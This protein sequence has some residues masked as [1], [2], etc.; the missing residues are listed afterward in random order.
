MATI[1]GIDLGTTNSEVAVYDN[2]KIEIITDDDNGIVPSVV[3]LDENGTVIVGRQAMNQAL[4][5]PERTVLSIKRRMGSDAVIELGENTFSPQEI[6]AFVLKS[7]KQRAEK[8]LGRPVTRAV[9]TV[10]AYFTDVQRQATRE[11]GQIAGLDVVR[12]INE[13]TAAALTYERG[14]TQ[15]RQLLVYDLGG[16]TFDVS[17]V[18]IENGVVEVLASTGDN[19]LGGDDFDK[20]IV[21]ELVTHLKNKYGIDVS[22][23]RFVMAR[24]L[25]VAESA[26]CV[27]STEPYTRIEEDH[28]TQKNGQVIHLSMELSRSHFESL[29]EADLSRTMQAVTRALKDADMLPGAID[30]II[31]VGGST[32][33]PRIAQ[34][35]EEKFGTPPHGEIDPDLCVAMGAGIQSAREMGLDHA[36]VL[37]DITPYTF[38]TSAIGEINGEPSMSQFVPLIRRNTKLPA[39]RSEVFYTLY[40]NQEA[41]DV[42]VYQAKSPTPPTTSFWANICST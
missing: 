24:L 40:D 20:K 13:P 9:I 39:S 34:L 7:L 16:G 12:I 42:T 10:P 21:A 35:L 37:V 29:I 30:Q 26:K 3:G 25:R 11:A 33:I 4:V 31:L 19:K 41:V 38:G 17:I 18:K 6:S 27:L 8:H 5:A 14:N 22:G 36:S 32:R 28:L 2:G 15:T 23:D 1:V